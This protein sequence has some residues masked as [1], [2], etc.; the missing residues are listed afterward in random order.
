MGREMTASALGCGGGARTRD[1]VG[2]DRVVL[3]LNLHLHK[4]VSHSSV[5]VVQ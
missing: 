3:S 2:R 4:K 1:G 5:G